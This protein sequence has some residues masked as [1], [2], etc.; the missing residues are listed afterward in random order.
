M[1]TYDMVWVYGLYIYSVCTAQ[2]LNPSWH[3]NTY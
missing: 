2:G 1:C 3:H